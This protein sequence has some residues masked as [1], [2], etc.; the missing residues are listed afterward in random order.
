MDDL[1][2][3]KDD[4]R[5]MVA[6]SL[7]GRHTH[8]SDKGLNVHI[9][10][11]GKTFIARGRIDGKAFGETLGSDEKSAEI[12]LRRVLTE[13]DNGRFVRPSAKIKQAIKSTVPE[14][15]SFAELC[16]EYVLETRKLKGEDTASDYRAR[17]IHAIRFL[18]QP[19]NRRRWPYARNL[20]RDFAIAL[21]EYL[22]TTKTTR[23]GKPG[24]AAKPLSV[25]HV[26]NVME[27]VRTAL[28]WAAR[29]DKHLLPF[30]FANP[31]TREIVGDKPRKDPMRK[32]IL[33]L[34]VRIALVKNLDCWELATIG[35][36]ALLPIRPE[37]LEGV[38]IGDVDFESRTLRI[39][40]RFKGADFTKGKTDLLLPLPGEL[41][42]VLNACAAGRNEG[43][44]LR[45]RAI[46]DW[47]KLPK[48]DLADLE[49]FETL[50]QERLIAAGKRT[51]SA[52]DRKKIV[53]SLLRDLGGV[54]TNQVG[55][56]FK[57][58]IA[59]SAGINTHLY[60]LRHAVTT[61]MNRAG[62]RLL[63]LRYLTGHSVREIMNE[64]VGLDPQGEMQKYFNYAAPLLKAIENRGEELGCTVPVTDP[65][66]RKRVVH[67]Y[68]PV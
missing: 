7:W 23:N 59:A 47:S 27:C 53:R 36:L 9:W 44:L 19:D 60:Q 11:R 50:L 6:A 31:M 65:G 39:G 5:K 46:W 68:E 4:N 22:F 56:D 66:W 64:Y 40:T 1:N 10:R 20:D 52:N 57:K 48:L 38:L 3:G 55:K 61:D 16:N 58:R 41:M 34:D 30:D 33:P 21:K 43:P 15:L 67:R 49:H 35:L 42:P 45:R 12:K 13:I 18:E 37:E 14:R 17:L 25:R 26:F 24:A 32:Q 51:M 2:S 63:E 54:D 62:I 29:P 28:N 8:A